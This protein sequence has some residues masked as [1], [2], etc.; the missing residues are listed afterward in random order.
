MVPD[1]LQLRSTAMPEDH[2]LLLLLI[3]RIPPWKVK[4][5]IEIK[6]NQITVSVKRR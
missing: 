2:R 4:I 5:V 3:V 1:R 6:T